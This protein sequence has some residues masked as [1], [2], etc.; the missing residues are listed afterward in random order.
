MGSLNIGGGM[1][2]VSNY[3]GTGS[4]WVQLPAGGKGKD[5]AIDGKGNAWVIGMDDGIYYHDGVSWRQLPGGGRG[6][7]IT[8]NNSGIPLVIGL[9]YVVWRF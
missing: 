3:K 5:I 6:H 8:V 7:R 2:L 4:G 9:D 1:Q